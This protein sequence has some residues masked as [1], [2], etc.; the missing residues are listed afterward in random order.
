MKSFIRANDG[1]E[2]ALLALIAALS[3]RYDGERIPVLSEHLSFTLEDGLIVSRNEP[4]SVQHRGGFSDFIDLYA[5]ALGMDI[6]TA[7]TTF[8]YGGREYRIQ[9]WNGGY[10]G[11]LYTGGEVG[12][13]SRPLSEAQV[14]PYEEKDAEEWAARIDDLSSDEVQNMC[15]MYDT[16]GE[17]DQIRI[18]LQVFN[19][20]GTKVLRREADATYWNLAMKPT[21]RRAPSKDELYT[22][23]T[24]Y[25]D[26]PGLREAMAD[27][28]REDGHQVAVNGER[29]DVTWSR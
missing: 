20:D 19:A 11:T 22:V 15:I 24:L 1:T 25:V 13:Y 4:G 5:P 14:H 16:V 21:F 2:E 27:A 12:I 9:T 3:D 26:D 10:I 18:D 28:L 23:A 8:A 6:D 17:E 7:V 29:V